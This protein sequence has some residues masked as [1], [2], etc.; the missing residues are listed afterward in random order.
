MAFSAGQ[1]DRSFSKCQ[2]SATCHYI[3]PLLSLEKVTPA[4]L[5][6]SSDPFMHFAF[7]TFSMLFYLLNPQEQSLRSLLNP[8]K[9]FPKKFPIHGTPGAP[10]LG[11]YNFYLN[12]AV[13]SPANISKDCLLTM[14]FENVKHLRHCSLNTDIH[15][16]HAI[17]KIITWF[18]RSN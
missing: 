5:S 16:R 12:L 17:W 2:D 13:T 6:S 18:S 9:I 10:V 14:A 11:F 4:V 15:L 1:K 8:P 3:S 7:L